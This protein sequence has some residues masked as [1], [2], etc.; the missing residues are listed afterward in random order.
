MVALPNSERVTT[1]STHKP[2][3]PNTSELLPLTSYDLIVVALSGGKDSVA[4]LLEIVRLCRATGVPLS[5]VEAWHQCVDGAPG[6]KHVWDWPVTDAYCAALCRVLGVTYR[7]QWREGG[8]TAELLRTNERTRPV[9][10]EL[11]DGTVGTTGGTRGPLGTRGRHPAQ[12]A[13]LGTRWCSAAA[14]I[15]VCAGA[16]CN[17]PRLTSAT[18]LFVTGERREESAN[19]ANYATVERGRGTNQNRRVDHWRAVIEWSDREVWNRLKAA[20]I[21]PHPAY[22]IGFGRC[23]CMT[24]VFNG[25]VEWAAVRRIAPDQFAFHAGAE[26]KSGHTVRK[27]LTVIDQADR[28]EDALVGLNLDPVLVAVAV[29][30]DYP[31]A[32]IL[33]PDGEEWSLPTGAFRSSACGPS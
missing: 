20:R 12:S 8:L 16:V 5:R 9:R 19:R 18:V 2:V 10:F 4:C 25:F 1:A 27:G 24:C 31:D 7:R 14:K 30:T 33:V 22:R 17:D 3:K 11:S 6:S 13:N 21:V 15:D 26:A 28:G 32:A 29:G 23:S